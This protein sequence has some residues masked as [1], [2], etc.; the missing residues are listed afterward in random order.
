MMECLSGEPTIG[1]SSFGYLEEVQPV[2]EDSA[3]LRVIGSFLQ[4]WDSRNKK[5]KGRKDTFRQ[6][7][8]GRNQGLESKLRQPTKLTGE[9]VYQRAMKL[10]PEE[11]EQL[12]HSPRIGSGF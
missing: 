3:I 12:R 4:K 8:D 7:V 11:K 9:D 10:F 5:K 6:R 2:S 1:T